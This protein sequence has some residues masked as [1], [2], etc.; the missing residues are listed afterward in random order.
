MK[1]ELRRME[2]VVKAFRQQKI[3]VSLFVD[4]RQEQIESSKEA[5]A[6]MVELHTG[7]YANAKSERE[8]QERLV[9]IERAAR[10]GKSL[11]LGVN[12]GH[13]L[14]YINTA[15]IASIQEID[16]VSIGHAIIARAVIVGVKE[17]VQEMIRLIRN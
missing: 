8:I 6:D 14:D 4:P 9:E 15:A 13:G 10:L 17:A 2:D 11:G 12:A 3:A 7:E 16:E 5:G 1:K